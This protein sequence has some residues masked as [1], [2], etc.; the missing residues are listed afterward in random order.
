MLRKKINNL[1]EKSSLGYI[2]NILVD[3]KS[4]PENDLKLI[5]DLKE[6]RGHGNLRL[7]EVLAIKEK[8]LIEL[9]NSCFLFIKRLYEKV[10]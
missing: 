8:E 5:N 10:L 9:K 4:L 7:E 3:K 2:Y 6:L 1:P